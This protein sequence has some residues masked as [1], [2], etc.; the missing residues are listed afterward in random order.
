MLLATLLRTGTDV[1]ICAIGF[2]LTT[3]KAL[4]YPPLTAGVYADGLPGLNNVWYRGDT[5]GGRGSLHGLHQG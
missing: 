5:Y 2:Q 3:R 1:V 4:V